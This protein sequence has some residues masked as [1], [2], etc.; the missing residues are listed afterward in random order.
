M[1]FNNT[2]EQEHAN[3]H[4]EFVERKLNAL[5]AQI[6]ALTAAV[7]KLAAKKTKAE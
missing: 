3:A 2:I 1:S 5:A 6:E 4:R 7:E